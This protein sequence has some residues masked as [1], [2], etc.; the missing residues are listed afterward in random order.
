MEIPHIGECF[1]RCGAKK[2]NDNS[3]KM[4]PAIK[5]PCFSDV[6]Y[7]KKKTHIIKTSYYPETRWDYMLRRDDYSI[8]LHPN[9]KIISKV[10]TSLWLSLQ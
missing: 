4:I 9:P 6:P 5:S 1:D 2:N 10:L 7:R 8:N 3:L